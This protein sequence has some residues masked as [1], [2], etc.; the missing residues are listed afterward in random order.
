METNISEEFSCL[1]FQEV[2][3]KFCKMKRPSVVLP[4]QPRYRSYV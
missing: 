1:H 2:I 4:R 3:R